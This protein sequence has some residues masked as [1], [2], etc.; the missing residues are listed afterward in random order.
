[1]TYT[2]M[3]PDFSNVA[4]ARGRLRTLRSTL[5]RT[6][7]VVE[8]V[9]PFSFIEMVQLDQRFNGSRG[10]QAVFDA[11]LDGEM[12]WSKARFYFPNADNKSALTP[13]Q[14]ETLGMALGVA[15]K[16]QKM[17]TQKVVARAADIRVAETD[18]TVSSTPPQTRRVVDL[19]AHDLAKLCDAHKRTQGK[20]FIPSHFRDLM[21]KGR[22]D[23]TLK[24]WMKA[25]REKICASVDGHKFSIYFLTKWLCDPHELQARPNRL[26]K[27]KR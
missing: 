23:R 9:R 24:Q 5:A 8:A 4:E 15:H 16:H 19:T 3:V 22:Y 12:G 2:Q 27:L 21:G 25:V 13:D 6:Y 26:V 10:R 17:K 18:T 11:C 20:P 1:M 7:G 14:E